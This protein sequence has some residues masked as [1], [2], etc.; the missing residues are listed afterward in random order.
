MNHKIQ[1]SQETV[2]AFEGFVRPTKNY[3]PMPNVWIEVCAQITNL[4]E[5][6]VIQYVL[7]HTWGYQEYGKAKAITVDEFMYGRKRQ[8][9]T[10]MD[11][12][13]GLKSDR[14]VKDGLK[15]AI[16]HGYLVCEVD[17]T[18]R[19]RIKKSYALKMVAQPED[20]IHTPA[21][22]VVDT[23]PQTNTT[24][25]P[26]D[27]ASRPGNFYPSG[28]Q[29]LPSGYAESTPR[30]EK[31]TWEKHKKKNTDGGQ[32]SP[33]TS[34]SVFSSDGAD[35]G[36]EAEQSYKQHIHS[37]Q[38]STGSEL[39]VP[40]LSSPVS[41]AQVQ[42]VAEILQVPATEFLTFVV[43]EYLPFGL[44]AILNE[45]YAAREWIED[46]MRNR[47]HK[48]MTVTFF[49]RW[50]RRGQEAIKQQHALASL[51]TG[52]QGQ[53]ESHFFRHRNLQPDPPRLPNL[54]YLDEEDKEHW[55]AIE[56][57]RKTTSF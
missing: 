23:T 34:L 4:A 33:P 28:S 7:R 17:D 37:S 22:R 51:A 45:A 57:K 56:E 15:A 21:T 50:M 55:R 46:E 54:K 29:K 39:P 18:D 13:T 16:Q 8:N 6:K 1:Q 12:G 25:R 35:C 14:S 2:P 53:N 42:Q 44:N 43:A 26:G 11:R 10:R 40:S 32:A 31:D 52:S 9:G 19:A 20:E 49:W 5:L 36:K 30:S 27:T 24:K 3:F 48:R 41:Q 47:D 38:A